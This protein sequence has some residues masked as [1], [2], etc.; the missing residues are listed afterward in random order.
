MVTDGSAAGVAPLGIGRTVCA[1]ELTSASADARSQVETLAS[2]A[3]RPRPACAA[4]SALGG[5]RRI[6]LRLVRRQRAAA[7]LSA[8]TS[9]GCEKLAG[10]MSPGVT[11]TLAPIL[12]Q[13]HI[14]TANAIGHADAAMGSRIAREHAG[15]HG[16]ARPGNPLHVGH[17]RAAVDI[18]VVKF[19]LLNDAEDAHRRRM[20]AMPVEIGVSAKNPLAS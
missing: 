2:A 4:L 6:D 16:D 12:V 9:S 15:M 18:G 20:S 5:E 7:P 19:V 10:V 11:T 14:F 17:R 1:R 13:F 3:V 8:L